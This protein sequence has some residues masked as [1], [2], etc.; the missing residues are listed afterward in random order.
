MW[1]ESESESKSESESERLSGCQCASEMTCVENALTVG[2]YP[3]P[4][5][6]GLVRDWE[7]VMIIV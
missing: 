2:A 7:K 5:H 4:C 6:I 1:S 3:C